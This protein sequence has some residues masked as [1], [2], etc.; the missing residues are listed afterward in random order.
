[1]ITVHP[2]DRTGKLPHDWRT[3]WSAFES[4][5][6]VGKAIG[7]RTT[8]WQLE[9]PSG[10]GKFLDRRWKLTYSFRGS[11]HHA[12]IGLNGK[13]AALTINELKKGFQVVL[14]GQ[15]AEEKS[16]KPQH[17]KPEQLAIYNPTLV[18]KAKE[19]WNTNI[20]KIRSD[21]EWQQFKKDHKFTVWL[22]SRKAGFLDMSMRQYLFSHPHATLYPTPPKTQQQ[23]DNRTRE[24]ERRYR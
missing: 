15:L 7:E 20:T 12:Y 23:L 1:M 6:N 16:K 21:V 14:D 8:L 17:K 19:D 24:V 3:A 4:L 9:V 2:N 10:A 5:R 22:M 13:E 18:I 11:V